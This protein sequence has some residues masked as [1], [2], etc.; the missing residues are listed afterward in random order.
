MA[1]IIDIEILE[2]GTIKS[3]TGKVSAPNHANAEGFFRFMAQ[4]CGGLFSRK[5]KHGHGLHHHHD[6]EHQHEGHGHDH[7]H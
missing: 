5:A 6:H 1:D 4:K 3:S 2:D 7:T